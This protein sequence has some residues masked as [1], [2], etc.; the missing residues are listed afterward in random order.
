MQ[1]SSTTSTTISVNGVDVCLVTISELEARGIELPEET[2][3]IAEGL[4]IIG[5]VT[6]KNLIQ[7]A[8]HNTSKIDYAVPED[9]ARRNGKDPARYVW[10]YETPGSIFGEPLSIRKLQEEARVNILS[11]LIAQEVPA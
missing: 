4:V 10:S 9:W 2:M 1:T 8:G 3:P 11:A 5:R 6:L 7:I